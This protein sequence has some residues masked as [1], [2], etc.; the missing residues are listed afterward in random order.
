M[1]RVEIKE[2]IK[3][4]EHITPRKVRAMD[5]AV[6]KHCKYCNCTMKSGNRVRHMGSS[7]HKENRRRYN[8]LNNLPESDENWDENKYTPKDIEDRKKNMNPDQSWCDP[9]KMVLKTKHLEM[10]QQRLTHMRNA[11]ALEARNNHLYKSVD[12]VIEQLQEQITPTRSKSK[13]K[14]KEKR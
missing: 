6:M 7:L 10:H 11:K 1:P 3:T 9:C 14:G 13:K 12:Q 5:G 4:P 8:I 2:V